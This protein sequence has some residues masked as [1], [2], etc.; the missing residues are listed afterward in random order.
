M[1]KNDRVH[2]NFFLKNDKK[3]GN[4]LFENDEKMIVYFCYQI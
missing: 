3:I 4:F 2:K 1:I